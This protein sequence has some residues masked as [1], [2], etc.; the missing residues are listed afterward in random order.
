MH[1]STTLRNTSIRIDESMNALV[2]PMCGEI[3]THLDSVSMSCDSSDGNGRPIAILDIYCE[4]G[5]RFDVIVN[6]HKGQTA[7]HYRNLREDPSIHETKQ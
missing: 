1:N 4:H 2:C 7:F 3:Y 5:H 6:Q